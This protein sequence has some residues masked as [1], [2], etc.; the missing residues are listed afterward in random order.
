MAECLADD[1]QGLSVLIDCGGPGV[2]VGGALRGF[3][4]LGWGEQGIILAGLRYKF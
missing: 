2:E 1:R 3:A 4:E